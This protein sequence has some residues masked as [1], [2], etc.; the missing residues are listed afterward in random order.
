MVDRE[1]LPSNRLMTPRAPTKVREFSPL[2]YLV[3]FYYIIMTVNYFY[4]EEKIPN[5]SILEKIIKIVNQPIPT[6]DDRV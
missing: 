3:S 5:I 1:G 4:K 6:N 2:C